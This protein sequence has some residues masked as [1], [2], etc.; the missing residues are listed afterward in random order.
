MKPKDQD[1]EDLKLRLVRIAKTNKTCADC[2]EKR[3]TCVSLIQPQQNFALG[4]TILASFVCL[5]CAG[6][7][8]KLGTHI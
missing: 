8:R 2:P 3:P 5:E 7:H 6:L 4:S 1:Q